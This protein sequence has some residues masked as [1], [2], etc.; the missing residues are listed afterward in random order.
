MLKTIEIDATWVYKVDDETTFTCR[1]FGGAL[2]TIAV[3][4][5]YFAKCIIEATG[6]EYNGKGIKLWEQNTGIAKYVNGKEAYVGQI[7]FHLIL[8]AD[9]ATELLVDIL[10]HSATDGGDTKN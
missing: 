9:V 3:D 4:E 10:E 8:P 5:P 6:F 1:P 7:P 2:T